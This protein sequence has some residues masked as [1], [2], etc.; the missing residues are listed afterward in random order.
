MKKR[1]LQIINSLSVLMK[2]PI[3]FSMGTHDKLAGIVQQM[4]VSDFLPNR[5]TFMIN[6]GI[7]LE[8]SSL[9]YQ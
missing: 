2:R 6:G 3:M 8:K 5:H 4:V 9:T 7:L 1:T